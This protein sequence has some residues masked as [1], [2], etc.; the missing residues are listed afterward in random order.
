VYGDVLPTLAQLR[1]QGL[2]LGLLTDN[3]PASQR[4][5]LDVSGLATH[6]QAI[7]FTGELGVTKPATAGFAAIAHVLQIPYHRLVMVGDNL[8]RDALGALKCG[9]RHAFL[10]QRV[11]GFFNFQPDL[12]TRAGLDLTSLDQLQS[13]SELLW[14]I[15][16]QPDM[17][18]APS[19]PH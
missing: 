2:R 7:V 4:M 14:H 1:R 19:T 11:G 18:G 3:P 5:K 8:Y 10:I 13:L 12:A 17:A 6:F 9:Y 15:P 16:R